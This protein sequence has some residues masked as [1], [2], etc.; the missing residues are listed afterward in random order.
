MAVKIVMKNKQ[1]IAKRQ[2]SVKKAGKLGTPM[3]RISQRM[4]RDSLQAFS[5]KQDPVTL[6]AWKPL[7]ESTIQGRRKRSNQPLQD[8]GTLRNSIIGRGFGNR[9]ILFT[10]VKYAEFHQKKNRLSNK[11]NKK[12]PRRR[13]MGLSRLKK[14]QYKDLLV[15][16]IYGF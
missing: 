6:K 2:K 7:A 5:K 9:A 4:L 15:R 8:T 14:K 1:W 12:I 16:W 10:N 13:F 11:P 3:Q